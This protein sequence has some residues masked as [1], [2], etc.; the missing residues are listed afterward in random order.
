MAGL[1]Y[2]V[3]GLARRLAALGVRWSAGRASRRLTAAGTAL[4]LVTALSLF[5]SLHGEFRAW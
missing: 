4:A 1:L 3:V 5:W 2:V